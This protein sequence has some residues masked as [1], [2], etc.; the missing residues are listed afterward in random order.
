MGEEEEEEEEEEEMVKVKED[1][2]SCTFFQPALR[3]VWFT[4]LVKTGLVS[5]VSDMTTRYPCQPPFPTSLLSTSW[6][7]DDITLLLWT[8]GRW[9]D[10]LIEAFSSSS[11]SPSS[12]GWDPM[13]VGLGC[14]GAA[15]SRGAEVS[16][17]P[18]TSRGV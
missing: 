16:L 10:F 2:A 15:R 3:G 12:R 8:V 7:V 18:N 4:R 11:S 5:W 6:P 13:D 1:D 17:L 9:G 14:E